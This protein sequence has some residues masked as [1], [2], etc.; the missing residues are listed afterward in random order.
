MASLKLH[1]KAAA[2]GGLEIRYSAATVAKEND[3][4]MASEYGILITDVAGASRN[5]RPVLACRSSGPHFT[6]APT[7]DGGFGRGLSTEDTQH[8]RRM[9]ITLVLLWPVTDAALLGRSPD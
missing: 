9:H 6:E 4:C 5:K 1:D 8:P 7:N 2:T 3:S